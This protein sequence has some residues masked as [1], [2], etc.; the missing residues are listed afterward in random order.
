MILLR[1]QVFFLANYGCSI[2]FTEPE[3][4][5]NFTCLFWRVVTKNH[6]ST[7]TELNKKA[8]RFKTCSALLIQFLSATRHFGTGTG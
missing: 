4:C 7:Q 2:V 5:L 6:V 1:Y 3:K 8:E